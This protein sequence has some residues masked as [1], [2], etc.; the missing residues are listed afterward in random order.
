M[1]PTSSVARS[2]LPRRDRVADPPAVRRDGLAP[3]HQRLR[4]DRGALGHQRPG[5][6]DRVRAEGGTRAD[7]D[8]AES[9]LAKLDRSALEQRL[10]GWSFSLL[11][12]SPE[13]SQSAASVGRRGELHR[14]LLYGALVLLLLETFLAWK[15]GYH[16]SS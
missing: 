9:D 6:R 14:P 11:T 3:H 1:P 12:N 2:V 13:L 5:Q 8:P 15:F 10:P 4:S 7:P 16:D